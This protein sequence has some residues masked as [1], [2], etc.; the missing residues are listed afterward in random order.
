MNL[1]DLRQSYASGEIERSEL[2]FRIN[3]EALRLRDIQA[4]LAASNLSGIEIAGSE[5]VLTA[6]SGVR[7][8]WEP[9]DMGSAPNI[10][11]IHGDYEPEESELLFALAEGKK[12]I[13]DI[14]AN[15]GWFSLHFGELVKPA[16]GSVHAIEPVPWT[17]A[18][19]KKNIEL[20]GLSDTVHT[21][22][23]G[24]GD[25]VDEVTFYVPES[26][27]PSAASMR[28]LHPEESSRTV[29][30]H[31]APLDDL[32][33]VRNVTNVEMVK[34]DVEGAEL[35]V[36]RGASQ[37]LTVDQPILFFELL[38]K[39]SKSFGYH[40]NAVIDLLREH[41]YSCWAVGKGALV[42]ID[43]IDD[44]TVE[45]NFLFLA[46]RHA[47]EREIVERLASRNPA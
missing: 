1:V 35:M 34:C 38:R 24:L 18:R 46:D 19:L 37:L 14:G 21:Y 26:S 33:K 40:P 32:L 45:T 30:C 4:L 6:R 43:A 13:V 42:E 7:M 17:H 12:T 29:T 25:K 15:V 22:Q 23:I 5:I 10:A 36:L 39:W 47:R 20:N 44:E 16:G 9:E 31:L 8:L 3:Q 28:D 27:G 2:R 11:F 41:G